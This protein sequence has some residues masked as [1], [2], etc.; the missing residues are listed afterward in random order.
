MGIQGCT[1]VE[2]WGKGD[3]LVGNQAGSQVG[4]P[5]GSL[6]GR[7]CSPRDILEYSPR[8]N[9]YSIKRVCMGSNQGDNIG[10]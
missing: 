4:F 6:G 5:R 10:G 2:A 8:S 3:N 7:Q 9:P 1:K